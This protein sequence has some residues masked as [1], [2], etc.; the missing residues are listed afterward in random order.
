LKFR[1][2]LTISTIS[3]MALLLTKMETTVKFFTT[4]FFARI[5]IIDTVYNILIFSTI[6]SY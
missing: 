3:L 5:R 1:C 6:T 4:Y 2:L